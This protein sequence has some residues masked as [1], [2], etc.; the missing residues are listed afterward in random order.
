MPPDPSP[1]DRSS[2]EQLKA[3]TAELLRQYISEVDDLEETQQESRLRRQ[4][5]KDDYDVDKAIK[6]GIRWV[7]KALA[8]CGVVVVVLVCILIVR[9]FW[10]IWDSPETIFKMLTRI[11]EWAGVLLSGLF[12]NGIWR[13]RKDN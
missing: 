13:R 10:H 3:I 5:R 4:A 2:L 9:Y 8:L 11:L 6:N 7:V 1:D 12:L